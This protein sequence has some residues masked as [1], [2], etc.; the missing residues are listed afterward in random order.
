MFLAVREFRH[1][2][3]RYILIGA[4]IALIAWLV[5]LLSGLATGLATDN[6][7]SLMNMEADHL[8]FQADVRFF[9]HRSILPEE[10]VEAVRAVPGVTAAAPLG[11]LTV[12]VTRGEEDEKIDATILA[13]DPNSF[14]APR[15]VEGQTFAGQPAASVVVNDSFKR[16]GVRLGDQLIVSP[17]GT[18]LTVVGFT[19]GQTYNHLPVIF[20]D[21]PTWR[22]LKFAAPGSAGSVVDPIS[23]VAVQ[24][25]ESAA[26]RVEQDVPG[27]EVATRQVAL[28]NLPGYREEMGTITLMLAFLFVIAAFVLA[29]FFYILT[30]Q[31]T[32]QFGVLKA[33]GATT[34]F[35]ARDL[36]AQVI[37][38]TLLGVAAAAGLTYV[39]AAMIPPEIPF[40]LDSRLI[41]TYAV[42]LVGVGLLGTLLSL[43]RIAK[44]DPL[45]AIGR[46][47]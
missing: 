24:M 29:V 30:L 9:L 39:V 19:T 6:G 11:H 28:E 32:N 16:H 4:I 20:M 21:I 42:V 18:V 1:A 13:I 43:R 46:V 45:I 8:V 40:S 44:I 25:D 31:K 15:I 47:D 12:T 7:A 36:I 22:E 35:L 41:L 26:A 34:S 23:A 10:A 3:L 33:L 37:L 17:S 27:V 2:R 38:L 14:L 5:F